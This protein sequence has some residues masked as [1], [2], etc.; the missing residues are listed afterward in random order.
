MRTK[1]FRPKL[2]PE[3]I[4]SLHGAACSVWAYIGG[5]VLNGMEEMGEKPE[6]SRAHVM[7]IV[8]DADRLY[9]QLKKKDEVLADLVQKMEYDYLLKLLKAAF[10]YSRYGW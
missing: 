8:V 2:T 6:I 4:K 3:Q 5:D 7:E 9:F 1:A 10:P